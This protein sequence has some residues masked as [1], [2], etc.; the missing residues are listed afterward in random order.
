MFRFECTE[1]TGGKCFESAYFN[2]VFIYIFFSFQSVTDFLLFLY[3]GWNIYVSGLFVICDTSLFQNSSRFT[4]NFFSNV[5]ALVDIE[6]DSQISLTSMDSG[7]HVLD[8][9]KGF[10]ESP[11]SVQT[12]ELSP[13]VSHPLSS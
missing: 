12:T 10:R 3:K 1:T 9:T 11:K 6:I 8:I 4:P 5:S 2:G 13:C 7:R